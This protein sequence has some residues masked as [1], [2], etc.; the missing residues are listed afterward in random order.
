MTPTHR[1]IPVHPCSRAIVDESDF[2]LLSKFTWRLNTSGYAVADMK[3]PE[4]KKKVVRMHRFILG[5][6]FSSL[7]L[8]I[9]HIDNDRLDNRKVNLRLCTRVQNSWNSKPHRD[10]KCPFKGVYPENKKWLARIFIDGK[11]RRIGLFNTPEEAHA[12]YLK[13]ARELCGEFAYGR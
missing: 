13:G 3:S 12:A 11:Y 6:H 10:S 2:S 4:G 5:V 7:K 1:S 9:D 8:E